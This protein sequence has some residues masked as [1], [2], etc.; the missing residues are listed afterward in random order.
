M[1][2]LKVIPWHVIQT[3][4]N[5]SPNQKLGGK[6]FEG[7]NAKTLAHPVRAPNFLKNVT[8]LF[9]NI[10]GSMFVGKHKWG[11]LSTFL[12][13]LLGLVLSVSRLLSS[14]FCN[15]LDI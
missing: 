4:G 6:Q 3:T 14:E 7:T 10:S 15:S 8:Y 2:N 11:V 5:I 1:T 9:V 13:L 12:F